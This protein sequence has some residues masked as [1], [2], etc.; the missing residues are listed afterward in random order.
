M[1]L[2]KYLP[3]I[4]SQTSYFFLILLLISSCIPHKNIVYMQKKEGITQKESFVVPTYVYTVAKGDVLGVDIS[5]FTKG[6][7]NS[8][9]DNISPKSTAGGSDQIQSGYTVNSQGE[10]TLPLI[11]QLKVEG[12]TLE[13]M[14]ELITRKAADYINNP[15][16]RVKMLSFYITFLGDVA[17]PGRVLVSNPSIN[18]YEALALAGDL[19]LTA[20]QQKIR[21]IRIVK[22]E[23]TTFY[24]DI[25]SAD[26]FKSEVFYLKPGDLIYVEPTKVK[27]VNQN[28]TG[29]TIATA[30]LNTLFFVANM[31]VILR[32][33]K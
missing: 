33:I 15:V 4:A 16:I 2:P 28:L 25:N 8:I 13:Q 12:L 6:G 30:V 3:I 21:I 5:T 23:A 27:V 20:N 9:S 10:I 14:Q 19:Q 22:G 17:K 29:L 7:I 1:N 31:F 32:T 26:V 18:I 24:I 11:G